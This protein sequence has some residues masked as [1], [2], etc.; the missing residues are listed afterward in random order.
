LFKI[1]FVHKTTMRDLKQY[2]IYGLTILIIFRANRL[3]LIILYW[4]FYIKKLN[5]NKEST[6]VSYGLALCI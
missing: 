5:Y 2:I 1:P 6:S 3:M 4:N